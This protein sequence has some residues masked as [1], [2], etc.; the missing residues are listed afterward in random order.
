MDILFSISGFFLDFL[1]PKSE[2]TKLLESLSSS[3]MINKFPSPRIIEDS[4]VIAIFDYQNKYV[5][6]LVWEIKYKGNKNL[7]RNS[8]EI[9][10]EILCHEIS[11]R[12]LSENFKSP[13][14][15]PMPIS[16]K[17]RRGRGFN[18]TEIVCEELVR[19]DTNQ[20]FTYRSDILKKIRHTKSQS[21]T[22]SKKERMENLRGSMKVVSNLKPQ[23][24]SV[25]LFDD[26][27]T[28][29]ASIAE[30]RR[31]LREAGVTKV[32]AITLAH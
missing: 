1:F 9:I 12:V 21:H 31:A 15:I 13:L 18:Q 3:D 27:V 19:L 16:D 20:L 8:A 29:G 30:A 32:L 10:Y 5:K 14:L 17:K 22:H 23:K 11:E 24:Y 7:A 2:T 6:D 4:R 26:V 25:V 28:T